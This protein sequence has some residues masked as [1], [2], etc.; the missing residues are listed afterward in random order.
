LTAYLVAHREVLDEDSL[1]RLD[2][3]PLRVLDSK[4]PAMQEMLAAAPLLK[5]H[6]DDESHVHFERVEALLSDAGVAY[7]INPRLVRGLDYYTRTVFEWVTDQL[8]AQS[9]VCSGGRYDGLVAQLGGR[10]T[11]AVGWALGIER[12]VELMK[13]AS[14]TPESGE[15]DVFVACV[16]DDARRLGF[17]FA[18]RLRSLDPDLRVQFGL[19][20]AGLKAQ[21]RRADRSG[22]EYALI[23]GEDEARAGEVTV[24]ALRSDAAQERM[25]L[26]TFAERMLRSRQVKP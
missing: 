1:R 5:D 17:G 6:L 8:G 26:E 16:G 25:T 18:E 7:T 11:P 15:A 3:N 20:T 14:T 13:L 24:K 2:R 23:V 19:A 22:A 12:I 4:N 9:A 10:A 21:M